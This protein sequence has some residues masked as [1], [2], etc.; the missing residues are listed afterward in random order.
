MLT[1]NN[2]ALKEWAVAVRSLERGDHVLTLRKGGITEE[3]GRFRAEEPEFFLFPNHTHQ[4]PAQLKPQARGLLKEVEA[5]RPDPN[6]VRLSSYACVKDVLTITSPETLSLLEGAHIWTRDYMEER[7]QYRPEEPL[8]GLVLRVYLL[9]SPVDLVN[10][11]SY[12]GCT[13]WVKLEQALSTEGA[14]PVLDDATFA[15]R[16]NALKTLVT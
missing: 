4:N 12:G 15:H 2:K 16:A 13:S 8:L 3:G 6:V 10:L 7:L 1:H 11:A 9:P 5:D 14:R